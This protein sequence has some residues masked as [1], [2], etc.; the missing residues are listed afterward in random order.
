VLLLA[1]P[2]GDEGRSTLPDELPPGHPGVRVAGT[3]VFSGQV[4]YTSA[5]QLAADQAR[6]RVGSGSPYGWAPGARRGAARLAMGGRG[7]AGR[8]AAQEQRA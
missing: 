5:E 8:R 6:H 4:A 2:D 7:R 3:V 1:T